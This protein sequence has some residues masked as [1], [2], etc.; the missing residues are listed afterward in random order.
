MWQNRRKERGLRS[1]HERLSDLTCLLLTG[2]QAILYLLLF[3]RIEEV[4][5]LDW[6]WHGFK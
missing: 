5:G 2:A 4:S 6:R 1:V 3:G